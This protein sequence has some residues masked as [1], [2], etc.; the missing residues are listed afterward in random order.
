VRL[1]YV[2]ARHGKRE[3][4]ILR[5]RQQLDEFPTPLPC[6]SVHATVKPPY[7]PGKAKDSPGTA[8]V[9]SACLRL[10]CPAGPRPGRGSEAPCPRPPPGGAGRPAKPVHA[11]CRASC[12]RVYGFAAAPKPPPAAVLLQQILRM[13]F[14]GES[15][16]RSEPTAIAP[17]SKRAGHGPA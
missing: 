16:A 2:F 12:D 10:A 4:V 13:I 14:K 15:E 8:G 1:S 7:I 9:I 5:L 11:P 17:N 6:S 3:V